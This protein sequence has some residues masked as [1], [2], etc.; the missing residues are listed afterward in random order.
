MDILGTYAT[1]AQYG[2]RSAIYEYRMSNED[3]SWEK[4]YVAN[5][6]FDMILLGRISL[7]MDFYQKDTKDL[8]MDRPCICGN[9]FC[10]GLDNVGH[11]RNKGFEL[12]ARSRNIERKILP[13]LHH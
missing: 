10:V 7:S 1:N 2:D 13:G 12:E 3:L 8:L 9:R 11:M 4:G 5:I 6:G